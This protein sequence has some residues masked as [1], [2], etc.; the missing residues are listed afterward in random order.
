MEIT[1][2]NKSLQE[3]LKN[4]Q[5]DEESKQST[6]ERGQIASLREKIRTWKQ[7]AD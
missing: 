7:N 2:K 4:I 3:P 5:E 6:G 1:H